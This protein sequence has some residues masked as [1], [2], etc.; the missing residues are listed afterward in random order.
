MNPGVQQEQTERT[1]KNSVSS[2][3]SCSKLFA[4]SPLSN[5][6][7]LNPAT[8]SRQNDQ[9]KETGWYPNFTSEVH[10]VRMIGPK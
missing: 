6:Q 8:T 5:S 10:A 2:V 9:Q 4:S 7:T 3:A 1:E